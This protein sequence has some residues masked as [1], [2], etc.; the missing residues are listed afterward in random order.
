MNFLSEPDLVRANS[1]LDIT[2]SSVC[3]TGFD[4]DKL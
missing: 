1:H 4:I 3:E 2:V